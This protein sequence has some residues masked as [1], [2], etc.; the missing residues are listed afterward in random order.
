MDYWYNL[1]GALTKERYPSGRE[2]STGYDTAGRMTN[3]SGVKTGETNKTYI[4]QLTYTAHGAVGQMSLGNTLIE[5]TQFNSRLQ[6]TPIKLGTP[7]S[8]SSALELDDTYGVR[9]GSVLDTTK[10]NGNLEGQRI[11]ISRALD[12]TESY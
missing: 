3:L 10:N 7:A 9:T 8:P 5:Q 12:V 4:S 2:V 6:P 1:A 11:L